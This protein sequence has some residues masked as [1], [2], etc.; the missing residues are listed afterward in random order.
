MEFAEGSHPARDEVSSSIRLMEVTTGI[1]N[2]ES[3]TTFDKS[4]DHPVDARAP[5]ILSNPS[6]PGAND[7]KVHEKYLPVAR[8]LDL[9]HAFLGS[10][11]VFH[12]A[13]RNVVA[14]R[15]IC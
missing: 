13:G 5:E 3:N 10:P 4:V 7:L 1:F 11:Y 2:R 14:D 12:C 8:L 15:L 9:S 6:D